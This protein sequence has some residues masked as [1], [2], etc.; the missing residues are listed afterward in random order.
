MI[1][2]LQDR[3]RL[4][5]SHVDALVH[6][7]AARDEVARARHGAFIR[8]HL[9]CGALAL[10]LLPMLLAFNGVTTL[11][12]ALVL[13]WLT[14]HLPLA[15]YVSR[16]GNLARGHLA[17]AV[18]FAVFFAGLAGLTGGL[19]SPVLPFLVL[20]PL[21]AALAGSRR[22]VVAMVGLSTALL[23]GLWM[24]AHGVP[25]TGAIG[26]VLPVTVV[27]IVL[28]LLHAALLAVRLTTDTRLQAGRLAEASRRADLL[29]GMIGE[30]V[31]RHAP[32]GQVEAVTPS[33][34]ALFGLAPNTGARELSG[35]GLFARVHVGDRPAYLKALSDAAQDDTPHRIEIRVRKGAS[36][37]GE[38]GQAAH[39][40]MEL[41]CRAGADG[42]VVSVLRD[43]D[44]E[45]RLASERDLARTEAAAAQD[46]R[47][48]FLATVSHELRT[49][50]NAILGFS[51]LLRGQPSGEGGTMPTVFAA[52]PART[53][54]YAGL[55][56]QSGSHLLQIVNDMLNMARIEAG[57]FEIRAES[58]D[59]RACLDGCRRMM[60]PEAA[61]LGLRLASDLPLALGTFSADERA[62]R[63][64]ALN[65]LSNA[66]KFTPEGGR[67]VLFA[68]AEASGLVFG[69][70][71]TGIGIAPE[72]Q[73]RV[74]LPFV[75][76]SSGL[77]R[78]HDGA[79]LGLSVVKGLAE[80]HGGR[81]MLESRVG[82]GTC[83]SI[84][85]PSRGTRARPARGE[86][87]I[88]PTLQQDLKRSA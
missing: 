5:A 24:F 17:S 13:G 56:H 25:T 65:L 19:E 68:R 72:D 54:E 9:A 39:A 7:G 43:V 10:A 3:L 34:A 58:F 73:D 64:I 6:P 71:D 78:L 20:A 50:L 75:Q 38:A 26:G 27:A 70:R 79:G 1:P 53:A 18:L 84:A 36:Q 21:E 29:G 51:D 23:A 63:Q 88:V 86:S 49:P 35:D 2:G 52:D 28:A 83:I 22:A 59:V 12:L 76:A 31:L 62:C 80:L 61:K 57:Q 81:M 46:A 15:M 47:S 69:V 67:V 32:G 30:A 45:K 4:A 55:I 48:R 42:Q 16:S 37:P 40:W 82:E 41:N 74:V 8:G 77:S 11:A 85:L 66:L 14:A 87:A 44:G 33:A 60:E